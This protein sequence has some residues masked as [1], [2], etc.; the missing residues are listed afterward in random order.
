MKWSVLL[1]FFLLCFLANLSSKYCI[2]LIST[3]SSLDIL[4]IFFESY[5]MIFR[6]YEKRLILLAI[7][8]INKLEYLKENNEIPHGNIKNTKDLSCVRQDKCAPS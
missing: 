6:I 4:I 7:C 8:Q 1:G 2:F 5:F 3:I